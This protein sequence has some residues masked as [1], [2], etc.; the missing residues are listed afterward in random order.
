M[1]SLIAALTCCLAGPAFAQCPTAQDLNTGIVLTDVDGG[2]EVFRRENANFVRGGWDDGSIGAQYL[3]LQGLYIVEY[4]DLEAGDTVAGSRV[5]YSYPLAPED[6]PL[7]VP[8][9][10][11]DT[12]VVVL[13]QGQVDTATESHLYGDQTRVTIG[14]CSYDMIPVTSIYLDEDSYT[15]TNYYL[16]ELGFSYLVATQEKDQE[17]FRYTFVRIEVAEG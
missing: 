6:A 12:E 3:L 11:W 7:P 16:P 15:E 10:R 8:G 17:E 9:G 2:Q 4:F 13:D 14:G 5:T 1:R